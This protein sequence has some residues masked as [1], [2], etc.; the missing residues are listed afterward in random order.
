MF[1]L[2]YFKEFTCVASYRIT[3]YLFG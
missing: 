1:M 2:E 3:K